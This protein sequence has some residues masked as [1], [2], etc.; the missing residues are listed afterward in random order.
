MI[1]CW[2]HFFRMAYWKCIVFLTSMFA[3]RS[4]QGIFSSLLQL[5]I[6]THVAI[7]TEFHCS[8]FDSIKTEY[9]K[10]RPSRIQISKYV[11]L[12]EKI[13]QIVLWCI[14][15]GVEKVVVFESSDSLRN[16]IPLVCSKLKYYAADC[17][18][19]EQNTC[20]RSIK[21]FES[22]S[23]SPVTVVNLH[24]CYESVSRDVELRILSASDSAN[25]FVR[26]TRELVDET[27]I[28]I[29]DINEELLNTRLSSSRGYLT[30]P[31][32]ILSYSL[33][34]NLLGFPPWLMRTP[35]ILHVG[36]CL[37]DASFASF[38]YSLYKYSK[39]EQRLGR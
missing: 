16:F 11:C 12:C 25:D 24:N 1:V 37:L 19:F 20:V 18:I 33:A 29:G 4:S 36:E 9:T 21:V 39:S 38:L 2:I 3:K 22:G 23:V 13:A 35:E 7:C 10:E 5:K 8:K 14:D 32:L 34:P 6:P 15:F 27:G 26:L 31:D 28:E 30:K 17:L